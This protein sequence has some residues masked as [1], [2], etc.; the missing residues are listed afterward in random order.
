[1]SILHNQGEDKMLRG[2]NL[3]LSSLCGAKCI[4][5]PEN[6]GQRIKKKIMPFDYVQRIVS[7]IKEENRIKRNKIEWMSLSEN[8]DCFYNPEL[9][10]IMRHIKQELPDIKLCI[11]TNFQ[12]FT[13]DKIKIMLKEDILNTVYCNIDGIE[14]GYEMVK[15]IPFKT[16]IK[17]LNDFLDIRKELKSKVPLTVYIISYYRYLIIRKYGDKNQ[18]DYATE[19]TRDYL[20][21]TFKK[22]FITEDS[23]K[24]PRIMDWAIRDQIKPEDIYYKDCPNLFRVEHEAFIAPDGTWYACCLDSNNELDLGNIIRYSIN[25]IYEGKE[26]KDLI[27]KL[28]NREFK[29]IKGPCKTVMCC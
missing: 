27:N 3:S 15:N 26:R 28:K 18:V 8:G 12:L 10:K 16:V 23:I 29:K 1:M 24:V 13:A 19:E 11:F 4:F 21:Y 20:R 7:E 14:D 25:E 22:K 5:C 2:I 9:I 17:N 6:R